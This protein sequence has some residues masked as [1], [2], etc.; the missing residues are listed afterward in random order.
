[1]RRYTVDRAAA[2][3]ASNQKE[4]ETLQREADAAHRENAA[5][6]HASTAA[7]AV[8]DALR[9][10]TQAKAAEAAAAN[11]GIEQVRQEMQRAA[12]E[13]RLAEASAVEA[14]DDAARYRVRAREADDFVN[15]LAR[16]AAATEAAA[17]G[18]RAAGA[19][20]RPLLSST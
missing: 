14:R 10:E 2:A 1:M 4:L 5:L 8:T 3:A 19:Y 6:K 9:L 16:S 17:A 18:M 15:T 13:K 7:A 12:H 20:T 11:A